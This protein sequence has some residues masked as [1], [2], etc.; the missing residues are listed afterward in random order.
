MNLT[1]QH[2]LD[3]VNGL[4]DRENVSAP[5][6]VHWLHAH[7]HNAGL[8]EMR[9]LIERYL[10]IVDP[11]RMCQVTHGHWEGSMICGNLMP[12]PKHG[13]G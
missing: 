12:C 10:K 6:R 2:V 1:D 3:I 7:R 13:G 11:P 9:P 5:T 4:L 8:Q